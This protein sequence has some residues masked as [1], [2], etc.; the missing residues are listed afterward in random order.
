MPP[1]GAV[2]GEIIVKFRPSATASRR[3]A[4]LAAIGG[5]RIKKFETI[6]IDHVRLP[7]GRKAADAIAD[8]LAS[9][10]VLSAQP[11]FIRHRPVAAAE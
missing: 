8:L 3:D 7:R 9:G 5:Q 4:A 1:A 6:D 11:N 10:E 2:D